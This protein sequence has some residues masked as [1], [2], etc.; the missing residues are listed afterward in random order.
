[1]KTKV[2]A[3]LWPEYLG[4]GKPFG[5]WPLG[6][7]TLVKSAEPHCQPNTVDGN[8]V[9][10]CLRSCSIWSQKALQRFVFNIISSIPR[11]TPGRSVG[12]IVFYPW[13]NKVLEQQWVCG[14]VRIT[15]AKGQGAASWD[16]GWH[17]GVVGGRGGTKLQAW[18]SLRFPL[19][20]IPITSFLSLTSS[21]NKLMLL[22]A[23]F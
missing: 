13:E 4:K 6:W 9:L 7:E 10:R 21:S 19:D 22:S 5:P 23:G 1:M 12:Q 3:F 16:Q 20:N 15:P 14:G 18:T 8:N 11:S 17:R 2:C